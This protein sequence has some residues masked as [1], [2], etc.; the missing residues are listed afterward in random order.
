MK[1][2]DENSIHLVLR[3]VVILAIVGLTLYLLVRN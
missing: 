1:A 3:I 2:I